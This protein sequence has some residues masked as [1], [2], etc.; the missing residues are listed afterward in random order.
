M[1]SSL[2][3][4]ER[5][6][7]SAWT[8]PLSDKVTTPTTLPAS[9]P[10][11][12]LAQYRYGREEML[13]FYTGEVP[14]PKDMSVIHALARN[15]TIAP[16][17]I[18]PLSPQEQNVLSGRVNS[19]SSYS[20]RG[21]GGYSG[22][23]RGGRGRGGGRPD[24][25]RNLSS[26]GGG[27]G[28]GGE[29]SQRTGYH[30]S[31]SESEKPDDMIRGSRASQDTNWRLSSQ[32][33][34]VAWVGKSWSSST[35]P[36]KPVKENPWEGG[37]GGRGKKHWQAVP[38]WATDDANKQQETV[39]ET[40][41]EETKKEEQ[42]LNEDVFEPVAIDNETTPITIPKEPDR[43]TSTDS[44]EEM[45]RRFEKVA[46]A[47]I[48]TEDED[49]PSQSPNPSHCPLPLTNNADI[50]QWYYQDPQGDTQGPFSSS[51]MCN[52]YQAGYFTLSLHVKR[53]CDMMMLPLGQI[54]RIWGRNPFV[55][56]P[57]PPPLQ[58]SEP[59]WQQILNQTQLFPEI[60]SKPHPQQPKQPSQDFTSPIWGVL[61]SKDIVA[62]ETVAKEITSGEDQW[63]D[64]GNVVGGG[65]SNE[66]E[67]KE[68]ARREEE[69]RLLAVEEERKR[70][71]EEEQRRL[72][73]EEEEERKRRAM[74]EKRR[75][76]AAAAAER[77]RIREEEERREEERKR[78]IR[79]E[80]LKRKVMEEERKR[81]ER[82]E[83][84]Q[85]ELQQRLQLEEGGGTEATPTVPRP[86]LLDIQREEEIAYKQEMES[87]EQ[88]L[89]E[90]Q[91]EFLK[92]EATKSTHC[93]NKQPTAPKAPATN[94]NSIKN[95]SSFLA[96]Q[97]EQK[98]LEASTTDPVGGANSFSSTHKATTPIGG[99]SWSKI[100]AGNR[101][102]NPPWGSNHSS[103]QP[104]SPAYSPRPL[105]ATPLLPTSGGNSSSFWEE[106][107]LDSMRGKRSEVKGRG[108]EKQ[109]NNGSSGSVG[110]M[111]N[112]SNSKEEERVRQ[113][114]TGASPDEAF[115]DWCKR[116]LDKY[117]SDVDAVTFVSLLLEVE[118]T[119]EVHDYI[120]SFLGETDEVHSFA[121]EFLERRQK[122]RNYKQ[123]KTQQQSKKPS[124][125][126]TG[127]GE[128][129]SGG[130][131]GGSST[132]SSKKKK[133]GGGGGAGGK[134]QKVSA[135][136]LLGFT[137]N[138][139]E[140][141]NAGEIQSAKDAL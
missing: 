25:L 12:P 75:E 119:Y 116:E 42:D 38:D 50:N 10:K 19:D 105:L 2:T 129:H 133:K 127:G 86:S 56:G 115:T 131:G 135:S 125:G 27:G 61:S 59:Y 63:P 9:L 26:S 120:K 47:I 57:H 66:E 140:R 114:F 80:E 40:P 18:S 99:A 8:Q 121:K 41:D 17:A 102:Q 91:K 85:R 94:S 101:P 89:S 122:I 104:I 53:G 37:G 7:E 83:R 141:P 128:A 103:V 15:D 14:F 1:S 51:E 23:G 78:Q 49:T 71:Y 44:V 111:M 123:T 76:E 112:R 88:E 137:V 6:T 70:L 35:S 33:K 87:R 82:E 65:L 73:E 30:R 32:Q 109:G 39:A 130:G 13:L 21:R 97:Q 62:E 74:E 28:G 106:C 55:P 64:L 46:E 31:N 54:V 36:V 93:W 16:L 113:L 98:Q 100:T 52:W 124:A 134:M 4:T 45:E 118:S 138:A 20:V 67:R 3:G 58:H 110:G 43:I 81:K 34:E 108:R 22:R 48:S 11:L 84:Q 126:S 68:K 96:I 95:K 107:A 69:A 92:Q 5:G 132:R 79:E 72:K 24:Y 29:E 77:Q 117:N 60:P 136:S 90:A 139:A